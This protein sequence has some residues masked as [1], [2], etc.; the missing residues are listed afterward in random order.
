MLGRHGCVRFTAWTTA[1]S[2]TGLKVQVEYTRRPPTL[3]IWHALSAMRTCT[4]HLLVR[5][6]CSSYTRVALAHQCRSEDGCKARALHGWTQPACIEEQHGV[7]LLCRC[8]GS[9]GRPRHKT[10]RLTD[11]VKWQISRTG[12]LPAGGAERCRWRLSICARCRGLCAWCRPPSRAHHTGSCRTP[13]S[14]GHPV[15]QCQQAWGSQVQHAGRC[16]EV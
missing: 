5:Q 14:P 7:K 8:T 16:H 9:G 6:G 1:S 15:R 13:D 10:C 4:Q 12:H 2:S 11:L 3:S